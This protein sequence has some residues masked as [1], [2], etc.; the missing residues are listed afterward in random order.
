MHVLLIWEEEEYVRRTDRNW[1][2][3]EVA[4]SK[5]RLRTRESRIIVPP[6][7]IAFFFR[8][9][10][11]RSFFKKSIYFIDSIVTP[12]WISFFFSYF[13]ICRSFLLLK[14][15]NCRWYFIKLCCW[16]KEIAPIKA[17]TLQHGKKLPKQNIKIPRQHDFLSWQN[18]ACTSKFIGFNILIDIM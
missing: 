10:P 5:E 3:G 9:F 11:S 4:S 14:K 8:F 16:C 6:T 7:C 15:T 13:W 2:T 1:S 12:T 17:V 18:H